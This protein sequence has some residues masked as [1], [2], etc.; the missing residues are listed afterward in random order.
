LLKDDRTVAVIVRV[1][2]DAVTHPLQQVG[3]RM[4]ALL[5]WLFARVFLHY[6]K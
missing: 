5:D 3:Q 6:A 2:D 4:L 1:D